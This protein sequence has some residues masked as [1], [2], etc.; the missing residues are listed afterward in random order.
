MAWVAGTFQPS[1]NSNQPRSTGLFLS[2][3]WLGSSISFGNGHHC[4]HMPPHSCSSSEVWIYSGSMSTVS[5]RM[6]LNL[7]WWWELKIS[8]V[9]ASAMCL[10]HILKLNVLARQAYPASFC[11][12][13]SN[14]PPGGGHLTAQLLSYHECQNTYNISELWNTENIF[15]RKGFVYLFSKTMPNHITT[16]WVHSKKKKRKIQ[17]LKWPARSPNMSPNFS[18]KN[19]ISFFFKHL[20]VCL[21]VL[22]FFIIPASL[23]IGLY[24]STSS[25]SVLSCPSIASK[26]IITVCKSMS[27]HS[28]SDGVVKT[29]DQWTVNHHRSILSMASHPIKSISSVSTGNNRY[30]WKTHI[31]P[32]TPNLLDNWWLW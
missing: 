25:P 30:S 1:T 10:Q 13:R 4:R 11:T 8:G 17:V 20:I 15:S 19:N 21:F 31:S 3:W 26:A 22:L 29:W 9:G 24:K 32:H 12:T 7:C 2:A 27:N 16:A 5:L 23:E 14:S 6:L 18:K 28:F